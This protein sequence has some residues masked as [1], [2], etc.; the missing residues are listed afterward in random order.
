MGE[1]RKAPATACISPEVGAQSPPC[2]VQIL[3]P[4]ELY[5]KIGVIPLRIG[6]KRFSI[7]IELYK[8]KTNWHTGNY[9]LILAKGKYFENEGYDGWGWTNWRFIPIGKRIKHDWRRELK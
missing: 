4:V 6:T 7:W 5:I 2:K 1:N 8:G 3:A 9:T